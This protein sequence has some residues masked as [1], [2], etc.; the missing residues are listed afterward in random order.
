MQT[1][2]FLILKKKKKEAKALFSSLKSFNYFL[3]AF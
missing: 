2:A 1:A 3:S